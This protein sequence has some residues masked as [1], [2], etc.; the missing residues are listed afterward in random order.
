MSAIF[1][2]NFFHCEE[3]MVSDKV[4]KEPADL[5]RNCNQTYLQAADPITNYDRIGKISGFLEERIKKLWS[6]TREGT[7][8]YR[9]PLQ[10]THH[11]ARYV[12]ASSQESRVTRKLDPRDFVASA[13]FATHQLR[14]HEIIN[15]SRSRITTATG[16]STTIITIIIYHRHQTRAPVAS[17]YPPLPGVT[18]TTGRCFNA[19]CLA[20]GVVSS[21]TACVSCCEGLA[22]LAVRQTRNVSVVCRR[23]RRRRRRD[24]RTTCGSRESGL[25]GPA[26]TEKSLL[27]RL[28]SFNA[29]IVCVCVFVCVRACVRVG[30]RSYKSTAFKQAT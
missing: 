15:S 17:S 8:P 21:N 1:S 2:T 30:N 26:E 16:N 4:Y 3:V 19:S 25:K 7:S 18:A 11:R 28:S 29:R 12:K 9:H 14:H 23:R 22:S 10:L 27:P 5:V 24:V 13:E 6:K 20:G